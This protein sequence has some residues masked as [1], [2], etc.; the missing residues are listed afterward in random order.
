MISRICYDNAE[1]YLGLQLRN[2]ALSKIRFTFE[3]PRIA[4]RGC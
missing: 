3:Q 4:M 1:R 2:P